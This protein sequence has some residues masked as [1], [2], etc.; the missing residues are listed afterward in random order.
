MHYTNRNNAAQLNLYPI[1]SN[2]FLPWEGAA[3]ITWHKDGWRDC[4]IYFP[5]LLSVE[6][7]W[8]THINDSCCTAVQMFVKV[9]EHLPQLLHGLLV[10][11]QEHGLKIHRQPISANQNMFNSTFR[12]KMFKLQVQSSVG[13]KQGKQ[14]Q[15]LAFIFLFVIVGFVGTAMFIQE[16]YLKTDSTKTRSALMWI[17]AMKASLKFTFS[18]RTSGPYRD[19][20][21]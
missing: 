5:F 10:W 12:L 2:H 17:H 19:E 20:Q 21:Q 4:S 13:K 1:C 15:V 6:D 8:S 11:L 18:H 16:A 7:Y 14:C 9:I 3:V